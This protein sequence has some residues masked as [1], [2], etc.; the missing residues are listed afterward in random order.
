MDEGIVAVGTSV[1]S[2]LQLML[3]FPASAVAG[4]ENPIHFVGAGCG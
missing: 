4:R 1:S 2:S 3:T